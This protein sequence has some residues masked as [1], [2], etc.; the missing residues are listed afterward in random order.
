MEGFLS[1]SETMIEDGLVIIPDTD[2]SDP[3]KWEDTSGDYMVRKATRKLNHK[4]QFDFIPESDF[5]D[6][7]KWADSSGSYMMHKATM[8]IAHKQELGFLEFDHLGGKFCLSASL[9]DCGEG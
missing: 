2:F 6:P 4:H 9:P 5:S 3:S 8:E 7:S 1:D